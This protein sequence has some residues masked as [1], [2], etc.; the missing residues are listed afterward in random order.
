M[1]HLL[2]ENMNIMTWV[3]YIFYLLITLP[4]Y[5]DIANILASQFAEVV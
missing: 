5:T 3:D 4:G 1:K 2:K